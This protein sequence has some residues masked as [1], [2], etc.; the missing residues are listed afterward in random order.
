VGCPA[1]K[2]VDTRASLIALVLACA[3]AIAVIGQSVGY[4]QAVGILL[5]IISVSFA[6]LFMLVSLGV[7][8][9]R[10]WQWATERDQRPVC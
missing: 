8:L 9:L 1:R 2:R 6:A 4:V 7:A 5:L 10:L 3:S